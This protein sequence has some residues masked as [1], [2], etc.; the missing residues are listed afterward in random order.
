[1]TQEPGESR[2]FVTCA[3]CLILCPDNPSSTLDPLEAKPR[4]FSSVQELIL[5]PGNPSS[6]LD[7]LEPKPSPEISSVQSLSHVR[8]FVMPRTAAHQAYL[9]ISN[10]LPGP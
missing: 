7:P 3:L 2:F 9:S 8:L 5:C 10:P 4:G 6:T 1:M